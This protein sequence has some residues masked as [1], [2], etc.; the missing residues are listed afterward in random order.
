MEEA[1]RADDIL[2]MVIATGDGHELCE[3][4]EI[5]HG[6]RENT[7]A[8]ENSKGEPLLYVTENVT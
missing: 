1:N 5:V 2:D 3:E 8:E 6:G 4:D 7:E